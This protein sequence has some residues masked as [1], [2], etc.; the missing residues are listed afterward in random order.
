R[1]LRSVPSRPRRRHAAQHRDRACR[2]HAPAA[3]RRVS[4]PMRLF[5]SILFNVVF[6][7]NLVVFLV[8]GSPLMF[9][10]RRWAMFGLKLWAITSQWWL[11]VVVGIDVDVRGRANV[12]DG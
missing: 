5:R 8:V 10:P 11:E 12:P 3:R 9:G 6:Y 7:V 1:D 2:R 4:R